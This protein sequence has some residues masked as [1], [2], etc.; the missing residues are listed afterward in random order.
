MKINANSAT[1]KLIKFCI[2][3]GSQV[4][5]KSKIY[6]QMETIRRLW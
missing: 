1:P 6:Q 3:N 4:I 2:S 5:S